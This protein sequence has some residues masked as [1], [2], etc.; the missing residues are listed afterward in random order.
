MPHGA[1]CRFMHPLIA[2][3]GSEASAALDA[4]EPI[5]G[6]SRHVPAGDRSLPTIVLNGAK[7]GPTL[8]V[9]AGE[10]GD[11]YEGMIAIHRL[12][13]TLDRQQLAGTVVCIVCCSV[14]AYLADDR[15]SSTDGKNMARCY[16]GD[17]G[18]TLTERATA[19]I[20]QDFIAA[21]GRRQPGMVVARKNTHELYASCDS[22]F[23][24]LSRR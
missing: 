11:E 17:A 12:A 6:F 2:G 15:R 10:H 24:A 4:P 22:I 20:Q 8:L 7:P 23:S 3:P 5:I 21:G 13:A 14:D 9:I 18:G 16:P 1:E 19:T